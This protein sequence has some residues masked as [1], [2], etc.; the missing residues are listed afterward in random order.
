MIENK[1]K[2][3]HMDVFD[4]DLMTT[5]N[6]KAFE[7]LEKSSNDKVEYCNGTILLSSG[8]SLKHNLIVR[9]LNFLLYNYFK[10]KPCKVFSES[11]E[12]IMKNEERIYKFKPDVVVMCKDEKTGEFNKEGESLI[13]TP[14]LIFEVV[15]KSNAKHD[16]IY[17]RNAYGDCGVLEYCLVYQDG[18]VEQLKLENDFY[19]TY[20]LYTTSEY[21]SIAYDD[22]SFSIEELFE[23]ILDM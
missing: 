21:K 17:K 5:G 19:E 16:I 20:N 18:K 23:D 22:L 8:T 4:I 6:L 7:N 14:K 10:N 11:I 1:D 13:G 2:H 3:K 15:S 9:K 12:I